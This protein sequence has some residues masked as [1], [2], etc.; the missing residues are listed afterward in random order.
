MY[1]AISIIGFLGFI[2]CII[3]L[4]VSVIRKKE[5]K[6]SLIGIAIAFI[7]FVGGGIVAG[8]E[9]Q[10][11]I[12]KPESKITSDNSIIERDV[13]PNEIIDN[14]SSSSS[15]KYKIKSI[16]RGDLFL[17]I[18]KIS[19]NSKIV[20]STEITTGI[21][22]LSIEITTSKTTLLDNTREFVNEMD[23]IRKKDA[24]QLT[25]SDYQSLNFTHKIKGRDKENYLRFIFDKKND[26]YYVS[27]NSQT[28]ITAYLDPDY[29]KAF[30][31]AL[32]DM[33]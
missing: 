10:S 21:K 28:D 1:M 6:N 19:P 4:I 2:G 33:K 8:F 17:S 24:K 11:V 9:P 20:E 23:A 30:S 25:K 5:K 14:S 32:E 13:K 22:E 16:T 27:D 7:L 15:D 31:V 29:A 18:E 12:A 3:W 26:D